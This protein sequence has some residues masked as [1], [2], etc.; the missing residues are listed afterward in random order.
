MPL[1]RKTV[2]IAITC[3]RNKNATVMITNDGPR[4]RSET[5]P[6]TSATTAVTTPASGTHSQGVTP[7]TLLAITPTV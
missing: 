2:L 1:V 5:R 6:S 4:E 3:T 7:S